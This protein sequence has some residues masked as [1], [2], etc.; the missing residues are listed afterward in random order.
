MNVAIQWADYK[1]S[2]YFQIQTN[3]TGQKDLLLCVPK[4]DQ[5]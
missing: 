1:S 5:I 3:K 4:T 2:Q